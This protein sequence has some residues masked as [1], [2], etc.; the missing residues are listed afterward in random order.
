MNKQLTQAAPAATALQHIRIQSG[1]KPSFD[2]TR[3]QPFQPQQKFRP[4]QS[5][6]PLKEPKRSSKIVCIPS[7]LK[8]RTWLPDEIWSI[9][10]RPPARVPSILTGITWGPHRTP[11]PY[12]L[13]TLP[14]SEP[15]TEEFLEEE[16]L[17]RPIHL[18]YRFYASGGFWLC[19]PLQISIF[20][21]SFWSE[22]VAEM[23]PFLRSVIKAK[24]QLDIRNEVEMD[25]GDKIRLEYQYIFAELFR[26]LALQGRDHDFI[27]LWEEAAARIS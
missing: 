9:I 27:A 18:M 23:L 15:E 16:K 24:F 14:R 21:Q 12:K 7:R 1:R 11:I 3:L 19:N 26:A 4:G 8:L 20:M 10:T 22:T 17:L 25:G 6:A 5:T 2:P 13:P